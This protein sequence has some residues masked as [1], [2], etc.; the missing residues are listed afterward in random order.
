MPTV[1]ELVSDE[2]KKQKSLLPSTSDSLLNFI[3][4]GMGQKKSELSVPPKESSSKAIEAMSLSRAT[5]VPTQVAI[6]RMDEVKADR[7]RMDIAR[8]MNQSPSFANW[9]AKNPVN[10][11]AGKEEVDKMGTVER[12]IRETQ[13]SFEN[14]QYT[15]E[16]G[17]LSRKTL[18]GGTLTKE[19]S[20][21]RNE[22]KRLL[23]NSIEYDTGLFA[24]V[25]GA[26]GEQLP[27]LAKTV[28]E[29]LVGAAAGATVG[30][31]V[32]LVGGPV[33]VG[34]GAGAGAAI[35]FKSGHSYQWWSF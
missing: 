22:L 18:F 10:H 33:G 25:P 12:I 24:G 11:A 31:S 2:K 28:G 8:I 21:R 20:K 13:Q 29:G 3:A 4:E 35:G 15:V 26:V 34:A 5:G 27:I 14:G 16:L 19:Q 32:G 1:N 9:M 30:A 23:K 6:E 17:N 7:E